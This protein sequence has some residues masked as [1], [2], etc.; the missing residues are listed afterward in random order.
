MRRGGRFTLILGILALIFGALMVVSGIAARQTTPFSLGVSLLIIALVPLL[1][2]LGLPDR[3]SYT[4]PGILL[5]V[6]WLLPFSIYDAILP[7]AAA[8]F[9][10][11]IISGVM[12]VIGATWTV[13]YNT[14]VILQAVMAVFG[15]IHALTPV[16]KT[17]IAYPLTNRFRT[18]MAVAMFSLVV[19]TLVVM[20]T[21]TSAF[22]ELFNDEEAFAG[23]F[24]IRATT[25][26][27]NPVDDMAAAIQR[28]ESLNQS[29]FEIIANQ[30]L[31]SLEARQTG[32]AQAKEF[33]PYPVRGL[34]AAFL[35]SNTYG[36]AI[37]AEGYSSPREVWEAVK[38]NPG[39]AI[40]D[41]FAVPRRDNFNFQAGVPEFRLEGFYMEDE[42]FTPVT[43]EVRDAQTGQ[44][45]TLTIIGVLN[46]TLPGF[47]FGIS[48]SQQALET[49]FGSERT[50]PTIHFFKLAA[51]ADV[52]TTADALESTF[53]MN[54]ME[55]SVLKEELERA[56]GTQLTF[57]YILQGFMGLGI[58]VGIAALGVIS[59]R[60]VVERRQQIGVLRAI[61][62][63]R[64]MVQIS[65]LLESS[66]VAILG[67]LLGCALGLI[68]S[69]NIITDSAQ[70]P[71]TENI[72]F[73]VP[74]LNLLIIFA[75]AY[76]ASLATTFMPAWQ[77]S[78][79]YPAEA[80]RYE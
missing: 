48:T 57:N 47:M 29:D 53:L 66:F 40:V 13:M 67:I 14:D 65:F 54:G 46:D 27:I 73:A 36:F 42:S 55:A 75:I 45:T 64:G 44:T 17:A 4:I 8:D 22:T 6:W 56:V 68:L 69:F 25:L 20:A 77:A 28:S 76:A 58:V 23:G 30:S 10:I 61:G 9:S 24:D 78:R 31:L 51:A 59:A 74:W 7:D 52:E 33:S 60:S 26:Q 18:G 49:A 12:L 34:D 3:P 50:Q 15:R 2:R 62:F 39:L 70:Q 43:V 37:M 21:L 72:R 80:L 71:S 41:P 63:Q 5:V 79:V 11:F 1:R 19:F 32:T 35:D 16:L 38:N